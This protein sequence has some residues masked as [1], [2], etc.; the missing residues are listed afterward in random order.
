M[1]GLRSAVRYVGATEGVEKL[2]TVYVFTCQ[3][4]ISS[5][6]WISRKTEEVVAPDFQSILNLL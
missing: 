1:V 4:P 2:S 5:F 3:H 6:P